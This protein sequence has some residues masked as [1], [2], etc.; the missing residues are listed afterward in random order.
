MSDIIS[1]SSVSGRSTAR[2]V[3]KSLKF[4]FVSYII[5]VILLAVLA[6]ALVYT[7]FPESYS[8]PAV[9][10]IT[11]FGAFLS[12]FLSCRSITSLGYLCGLATGG[13]NVIILLLIGQAFSSS[14]VFTMSNFA[15]VAIAMLGGAVGGIMGVNIGK[16]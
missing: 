12:A 14:P 11:I 5:S 1:V 7:D 15:L 4:I 13:A 10:I 2:F 6:L 16:N 9:K 8:F 3:L